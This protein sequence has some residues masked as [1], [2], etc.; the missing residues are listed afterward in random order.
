[1]L[2]ARKWKDVEYHGI[3]KALKVLPA[4]TSG[5]MVVMNFTKK[6]K[7]QLFLIDTVVSVISY[8]KVDI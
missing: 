7:I 8:Y 5:N 3:T 2:A 6:F 1:M 4:L